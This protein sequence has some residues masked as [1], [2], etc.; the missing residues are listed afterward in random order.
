MT[1]ALVHYPKGKSTPR[2]KYRK[3]KSALSLRTVIERQVKKKRYR[4]DSIM[5]AA[6]AQAVCKA[7][8]R[9]SP[10]R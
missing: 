4:E 6:F 9:L 5:G 2:P 10:Q 8:Q 7:A 3:G 1:K